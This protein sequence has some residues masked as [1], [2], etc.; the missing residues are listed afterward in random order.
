[1]P[2]PVYVLAGQSNA[3]RPG[4]TFAIAQ[5]AAADGALFVNYAIAGAP[6]SSALDRGQGDWSG[7][8]DPGSGEL[9]LDLEERIDALLDPSSPTY[10]PDAYVAGVIWIQG[11]GDL[12]SDGVAGAYGANLIELRDHMVDRYGE[13]EWIISALSQDAWIG[14]AGSQTA[15]DRW[16][17]VRAQQL[18][19]HELDGF[20]VID[21]DQ[22]AAAYDVT[23]DAM[24]RDDYVHFSPDFQPI[25]GAYL[26]APLTTVT[27][28]IELLI[29]TN[30]MDLLMMPESGF[31]QVFGA[32]GADLADFSNLGHGI[33]AGSDMPRYAYAV[34]LGAN[35]DYV[36]SLIGIERLQGT[37]FADVFYANETLHHFQ[38][39]GGNDT[40]YGSHGNETIRLDDGDDQAFGGNG[41]D[42]LRGDGGHDLIVG[43]GG[44]DWLYGDSG[45]DLVL[46]GSGHDE[47]HG[48]RG[49][50]RVNGGAGQD[51]LYAGEGHDALRGGSG[52]DQLFGGVGNDR[53]DGE[54]GDDRLGGGYGHDVLNGHDGNDNLWGAFGADLIFGGNGADRLFG[55]AGNDR[56]YGHRGADRLI[57]NTGD[58]RLSGGSGRDVLIGNSGAD[59]VLGGRNDDRLYGNADA[60]VLSGGH[61]DDRLFGGQGAD[62]LHGHHGQDRLFGGSG[63]DSLRDWAG[64]SLLNGGRGHDFLTAGAGADTL[65]GGTGNDRLVGGRDADV[66]V[67]ARGDGSDS[68][69]DFD[70][71]ADIIRIDARNFAALTIERDGTATVINY[72][73]GDSIRLDRVRPE[74]VSASDFEFV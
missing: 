38:T 72:G 50:D 62:R 9:R 63:H 36:V 66:F 73:N 57:G 16:N 46:G 11:E 59:R 37:R 47:M 29:G 2:T 60:D 70:F 67:F 71:G 15:E 64:A 6:L 52:D 35:D 20:T 32:G 21:P 61:G 12:N 25:L 34:G 56:L 51:T 74:D 4:M 33:T 40:V 53:L 22:V 10:I 43:G 3:N 1:M 41:N 27:G 39:G 30:E 45:D 26:A 19:L 69:R 54:V 18:A 7:S 5:A 42:F 24:F 8:T 44:N 48:G 31:T 17:L 49:N 28:G 13:H 23:I 65:I 55:G 68:I 14:R 58:D